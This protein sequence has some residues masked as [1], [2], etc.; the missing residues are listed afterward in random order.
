MNS[1]FTLTSCPLR[2]EVQIFETLPTRSTSLWLSRFVAN[3]SFFSNFQ[4]LKNAPKLHGSTMSR[5]NCIICF[6]IIIIIITIPGPGS[7]RS[8]RSQPLNQRPVKSLPPWGESHYFSIYA[9][10]LCVPCCFLWS[11]ELSANSKLKSYRYPILKTDT[12]KSLIY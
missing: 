12:D 11:P 9:N 1:I 6:I 8:F 3:S 5:R 10:Q 2:W 7:S 4:I